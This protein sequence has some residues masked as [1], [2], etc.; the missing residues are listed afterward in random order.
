[1]NRSLLLLGA[2]AVATPLSSALAWVHAGGWSG[3][4]SSWSAHDWRGGSASG[5]N[6]SWSA[7]GARG[8]TA[9]GAA[10]GLRAGRYPPRDTRRERR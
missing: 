2:L 9:S 6:G 8:G 5:G 10:D 3:D 1:M 7:T 4:R